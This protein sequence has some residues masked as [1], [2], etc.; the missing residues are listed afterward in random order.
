LRQTEIIVRAD[1]DQLAA[2]DHYLR[3]SPGLDGFKIWI[4]SFG[5]RLLRPRKVA[6]FLKKIQTYPPRD[7]VK[8]LQ[9]K[10]KSFKLGKYTEW[11]FRNQA[12]STAR[13][14]I[15]YASSKESTCVHW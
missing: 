8:I 13:I 3:V 15:S 12:N 11:P 10:Q 2:I 9:Q 4:P 1:H 7:K 5:S 6:T 14:F